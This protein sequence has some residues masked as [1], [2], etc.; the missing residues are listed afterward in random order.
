[1]TDVTFDESDPV[2]PM[3][4][5]W[6]VYRNLCL[7]C[8]IRALGSAPKTAADP[9]ALPF[10]FCLQG[11]RKRWE[12][13]K[14]MPPFLHRVS[15]WNHGFTW[16]VSFRMKQYVDVSFILNKF[17][18]TQIDPRVGLFRWSLC[19]KVWGSHAATTWSLRREFAPGPARN[20]AN[21]CFS[22]NWCLPGL[23][24][25]GC[26]RLFVSLLGTISTWELCFWWSW[27]ELMWTA[28]LLAMYK[29]KSP[30]F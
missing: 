5:G 11:F 18:M 20:L 9:W 1:M 19:S 30:G 22:V 17:S 13:Q 26:R 10:N 29:Q 4:H 21:E 16:H 2:S 14:A 24:T 6:S 8:L 28:C 25:L 15:I 7:D 27:C 23:T 3:C 12:L